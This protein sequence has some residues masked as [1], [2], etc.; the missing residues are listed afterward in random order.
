MDRMWDIINA[1]RQRS[2]N[3]AFTI[4]FMGAIMGAAAGAA[5]VFFSDE[6][7]RIKVA[8]RAAELKDKGT[9]KLSELRQNVQDTKESAK[10]AATE[11]KKAAK[12]T[13]GEAK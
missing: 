11:A 12:K 7:N 6:K 1:N 2:N 10:D 3:N 13:N 9:A 4:G 8:D 5:A